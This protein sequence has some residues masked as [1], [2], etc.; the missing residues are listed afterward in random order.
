LL[1][2]EV[3]F[4]QEAEAAQFEYGNRWRA[5]EFMARFQRV[6]FAIKYVYVSQAAEPKYLEEVRQQIRSSRRPYGVWAADDLGVLSILLVA[7]R[8]RVAQAFVNA[9]KGQKNVKVQALRKL[10]PKVLP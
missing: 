7:R 9:V 5:S 3:D 8:P 1:L 4:Y 2:S 6:G 10:L